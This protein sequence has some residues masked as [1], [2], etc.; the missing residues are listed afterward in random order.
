M[1]DMGGCPEWRELNEGSQ[2]FQKVDMNLSIWSGDTVLPREGEGTEN[3]RTECRGET[4]V[5]PVPVDY[6]GE[7]ESLA[8][9]KGNYVVHGDGTDD[10]PVA[11]GH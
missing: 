8:I 3:T 1:D 4:S 5:T 6:F 9:Q 11:D 2:P 7:L 10:T